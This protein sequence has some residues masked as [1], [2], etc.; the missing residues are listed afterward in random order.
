MLD[1][2]MYRLNEDGVP[3]WFIAENENQALSYAAC[4]WGIDCV[5]QYFKEFLEDNP[6]GTIAEFIGDF[7]KEE[8]QEDNFSFH[9][10]NGQ[11][12]TKTVKEFLDEVSDVPC[13][14]ACG[15]Y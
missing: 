5:L 4:V 12:E 9:H 2:K 11:M 15:N 13:Y 10:E 7:V 8:K 14:F 3:E 1:K 6:N